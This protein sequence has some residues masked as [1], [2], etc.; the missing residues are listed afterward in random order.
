MTEEVKNLEHKKSNK[1]QKGIK[2]YMKHYESKFKTIKG[3]GRKQTGRGAY[4]LMMLKKC[5]KS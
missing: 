5:C 1:L 2:D 3:S 4:F